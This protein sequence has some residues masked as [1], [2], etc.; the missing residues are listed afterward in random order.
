VNQSNCR[1]SLNIKTN[2]ITYFFPTKPIYYNSPSAELSHCDLIAD[3]LLR[4]WRSLIAG[5]TICQHKHF[6]VS[7]C[8]RLCSIHKHDTVITV[9]YRIQQAKKWYHPVS[10]VTSSRIYMNTKKPINLNSNT[11]YFS[12]CITSIFKMDSG[13]ASWFPCARLL[14]CSS[15]SSNF[16]HK[17]TQRWDLL[18]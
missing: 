2:P 13:W 10:S 3:V 6:R 9:W 11:S 16:L 14:I 4:A 1:R 18:N 12:T 5:S 17:R 7:Q 8:K 15:L